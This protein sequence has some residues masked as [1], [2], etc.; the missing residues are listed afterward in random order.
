[1]L[2]NYCK[3]GKRLGKVQQNEF[4]FGANPRYD[5]EKFHTSGRGHEITSYIQGG[6]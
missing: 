2:V 4:V 3:K 1:M 6:Q 5:C